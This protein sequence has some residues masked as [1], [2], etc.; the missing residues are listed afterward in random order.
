MKQL[1]YVLYGIIYNICRVFPVKEKKVVLFMIHNSRFAGNLRFVYEEMKSRDAGFQFVV[2]SKKQLFSVSGNRWQRIF[3]KIKGGLYFYLVLNYHLATAG[4]IFLNDNFLPL[5]YMKVSPKTKVVQ[6]WHG[7]GAFKRFGLTTENRREV[8][9]CVE[10]GNKKVTHLFVSSS[11]IISY[12]EEAMGIPRERIFPDGIP[13]TDYYFD[14]E[15]KAE[16][17]KHFY[18]QYPQLAGKKLLLYTPTFRQSPEENAGIWEHFD[19]SRIKE[20][21]GEDWALLVRRHPQIAMPEKE[22]PEGCYDVTSY[23]DS[24]E[25]YVAADVLVNDYSS[26]VVEYALL[27]KP[28]VLFAYDLEEY[29]RGFYRDYRENAPGEI[30]TSQEELIKAVKE[31]NKDMKKLQHF[32]KMQYDTMDGGASRRVV[33]RVLDGKA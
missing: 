23:A 30:V 31:E 3:G 6:L 32:Q 25:L 4:Y 27:Q 19:C 1:A 14:E 24:K 33:D 13:V 9:R 26:T 17:R 16:G 10:K 15:K 8:R 18:E 12:Y 20:G 11:Q 28:V 21:L 7:V 5:A 2:V 29:D 22:M